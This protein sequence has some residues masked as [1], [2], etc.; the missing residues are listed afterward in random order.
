MKGRRSILDNFVYWCLEC[1]LCYRPTPTPAAYAYE[2]WRKL[3]LQTISGKV[4]SGLRLSSSLSFA[5]LGIRA[6][7]EDLSVD[8]D[9]DL[10][11]CQ[12]LR[13]IG[14]GLWVAG[15]LLI[16]GSCPEGQPW[17]EHLAEDTATGSLY[18]FAAEAQSKLPVS[19]CQSPREPD[20]RRKPPCERLPPD[21][22]MPEQRYLGGNVS[23]E[24]CSQFRRMPT[25]LE[26]AGN[27]TL[28][29]CRNLTELPLG[30]AYRGTCGSSPY[31]S[32]S[33][34]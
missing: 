21:L 31:R 30:S 33:F 3:A 34:R 23:I 24:S 7:P 29:G 10:R 22:G 8:G 20:S 14:N 19:S 18:G 15:D 11:Q 1:L 9:L 2:S 13:R 16:G 28:K 12:R 17:E 32:S 26:I 6:I 25:D 27:L 4:P 5:K